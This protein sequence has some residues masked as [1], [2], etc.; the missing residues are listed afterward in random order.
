VPFKKSFISSLRFY[1]SG[2]NLAY[3]S[4]LKKYGKAVDP[5]LAAATG[6]YYSGS[7][8]GYTMPLTLTLGLNINF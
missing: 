1:F 2:E 3:A 5:E 7:G 6:T 4:P 8:V